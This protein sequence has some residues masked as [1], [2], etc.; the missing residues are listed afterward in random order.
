[1]KKLQILSLILVLSL[2][3]CAPA[4][5]WTVD[6][7]NWAEVEVTIEE[8]KSA[9]DNT[10]SDWAKSE[11]DKA[12]A[13][14]LVPALTGNPKFTDTITREQF[15][16]LIVNAVT[17]IYGEGPDVSNAAAF[18]DSDNPKVLAASAAGI[19]SGVGNGKF[20]PKQ[21]TNR[22]QIATM[23]AR[24]SGYL[25]TLTNKDVTPKAADISKFSDNAQVSAW[26][27]NG[28]GLLAANGIMAGTSATTLSPK[29]SCT[30]EQSILLVYRL[31]T[32][33][34]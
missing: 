22:E 18:T 3:L 14:G 16:E 21:T 28:V 30:V 6:D 17:V 2:C 13:A 26:A 1:M 7:V 25:K 5:A 33:M 19:V 23:M 12:I 34:Q 9:P 4:F 24:A 10:P 15:A 11:V 20:D 27:V 29:A 31:Y 8:S 32:A